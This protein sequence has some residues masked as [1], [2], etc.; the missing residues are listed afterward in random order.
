MNLSDMSS[1]V[2]ANPQSPFTLSSGSA[3]LL[4]GAS[5]TAS[6]D[7]ASITVQ[8]VS[9]SLQRTNTFQLSGIA[10]ILNTVFDRPEEGIALAGRILPPGGPPPNALSN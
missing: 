3:T 10:P 1:G 4:I 8:G 7:N 5:A 6:T 9:G 2:S